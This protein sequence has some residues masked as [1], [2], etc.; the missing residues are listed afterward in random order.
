MLF[1]TRVVLQVC[2]GFVNDMTSN[3][4]LQDEL[5]S[6]VRVRNRL[7][8]SSDA[9]LP[10]I[11]TGLLP[12]L[13]DRLDKHTAA[14]EHLR[15]REGDDNEEERALHTQIQGHVSAIWMHALE[16]IRKGTIPLPTGGAPWIPPLL[17]KLQQVRL[18]ICNTWKITIM[19]GILLLP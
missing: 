1:L 5:A 14:L 11:L 7:A 17:S 12:K 19:L 2:F 18:I 10:K 6:L 8:Q 4:Q 13:A 3:E 9:S 16:R 15:Q